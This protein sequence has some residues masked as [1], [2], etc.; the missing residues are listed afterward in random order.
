[1]SVDQ[2]PLPGYMNRLVEILVEEERDMEVDGVSGGAV[3]PCMEYLLQ[4]RVLDTMYTFARTDVRL[5]F[6]TF[7][8]FSGERPSAYR[9][10]YIQL[11]TFKI[12]TPKISIHQSINEICIA[13]PTES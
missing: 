8:Q 6:A 13:P 3:G 7:S 5:C 12:K 9:P 1:M 10:Q 11:A 2:T 4:H